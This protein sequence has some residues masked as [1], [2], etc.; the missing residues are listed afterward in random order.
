MQDG[1]DNSLFRLISIADAAVAM[2]M[3]SKPDS[4]GVTQE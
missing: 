3:P 4:T 2:A 1:K